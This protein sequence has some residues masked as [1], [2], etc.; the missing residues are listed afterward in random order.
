ML[1]APGTGRPDSGP[2]DHDVIESSDSQ[3]SSSDSGLDCEEWQD[4]EEE[5]G[6]EESDWSDEEFLLMHEMYGI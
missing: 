4:D 2:T 1:L 3:E 5:G 6:G